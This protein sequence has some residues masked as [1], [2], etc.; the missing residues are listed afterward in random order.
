LCVPENYR[1]VNGSN[2]EYS[3]GMGDFPLCC[4][5]NDVFANWLAQNKVG[6]AVTAASAGVAIGAGIAT[7]NP[8]MAVGGA[9]AVANELAQLYKAST[10]PDQAKGNINGGTLNVAMDKQDFFFSHMTIKAEFAKRLDQF[11]DMYGYKVNELKV[12]NVSGRPY[13][14]YVQTIDINIT[15]AIPADDMT[16]LKKLYNEGVTLWHSPSYF[17]NYALNNH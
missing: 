2:F 13:W 9:M 6:M 14:N 10:Q 12:P 11:F 4:W 3:L 17:C 1:G 15:G 16:T 7:A 5:G 8:L